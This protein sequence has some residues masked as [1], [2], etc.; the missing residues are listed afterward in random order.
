MGANQMFEYPPDDVS[1]TNRHDVMAYTHQLAERTFNG[2]IPP[3]DYAMSQ[4]GHEMGHRWSAFVS[5]KMNGELIPLGPTHWATG[6]Q[7][8]VAFP[9]QRPVEASAMGGGVWQDN[10][11][12]TWTQLDDDYY[13]PATGWSYLDLYLMGFIAPSEVP[14]FFLLRDLVPQG[15]DAN[16]HMIYKANRTK[17]TINDV[18]AAEGPRMPDVDHAQK[19]FNTGMVVVLEHGHMPP[20]ELLEPVEGVRLRWMDYWETTTGHRSIMTTDPD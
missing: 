7:A 1:G 15:P 12:G 16:G 19:R 10:F 4:I 8:P 2:K 18:I 6:L 14:D 17:V 9:Y 5:A 13:V 11:D 20:P 3:Y